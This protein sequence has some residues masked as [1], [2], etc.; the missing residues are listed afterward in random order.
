MPA[1]EDPPGLKTELD[2]LCFAARDLDQPPKPDHNF[3][4]TAN[5]LV[6]DSLAEF[7]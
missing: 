1:T 2:F 4:I 6:M 5:C 7:N 3:L